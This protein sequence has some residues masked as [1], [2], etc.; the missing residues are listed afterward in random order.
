[1]G[2]LARDSAQALKDFVRLCRKSADA[3]AD[4][5]PFKRRGLV[6]SYVSVD[7]VC[8]V[9]L[10]DRIAHEFDL[11]F[12]RVPNRIQRLKCSS[13]TENVLP[14]ASDIGDYGNPDVV[15]PVGKRCQLTR[16]CI[17]VGAAVTSAV[18]SQ[19]PKLVPQYFGDFALRDPLFESGFRIGPRKI[20]G[21]FEKARIG[22]NRGGVG[23]LIE[24]TFDVPDGFGDLS[25]RSMDGKLCGKDMLIDVLS[26]LRVEISDFLVRATLE[27]EAANLVELV[28]CF[29]APTESLASLIE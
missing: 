10:S 23:G 16:N 26:G 13:N 12:H 17:S 27:K 29:L 25:S 22:S 4:G 7:A 6:K 18:W 20:P 3:A 14:V 8:V 11:I 21:I 9:R 24:G 2:D 5:K 1:M 28:E 15:V 19:S